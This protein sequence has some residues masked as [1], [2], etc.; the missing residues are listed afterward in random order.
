MK[1][2]VSGQ[3]NDLDYVRSVQEEFVK[4]GHQI[5]HDWTH[6]ETGE[7]MLAGREAK[8]AN[9]EEAGKRALKDLQGVI[10]CDVYVIC[11]ENEKMGKGMYAE[12]GAA[13]A[14]NMTTGLPDIYLLGNRE[15]ASIFYFHPTIIFRN[16]AVEIIETLK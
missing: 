7:K 4:A 3:I 10:D 5:T 9:P 11:T 13:L 6:N 14:L 15:H 12:L 2:F 1:I 16:S 8:F